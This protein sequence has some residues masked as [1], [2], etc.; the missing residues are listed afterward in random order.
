MLF[1]ATPVAVGDFED[2]VAAYRAGDHKKAFRLWKPFAERGKAG[3]QFNLG[4]MYYKGEG[5]L[6]DYVRA[7]AWLS[8]AEA[9]RD[10]GKRKW[11]V[12]KRMTPA[13]IA[14]AQKLSRE[15]W[16]NIRRSLPEGITPAKEPADPNKLLMEHTLKSC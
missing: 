16:A 9:Q 8:I 4:V 11:V 14:E 7:Y 13:Q 10:A 2:G 15:L 3:A 6:E 5:V 1:A 12:A